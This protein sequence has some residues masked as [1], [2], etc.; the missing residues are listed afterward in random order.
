MGAVLDRFFGAQHEGRKHVPDMVTLGTIECEYA[1]LLHNSFCKRIGEG[2]LR[3]LHDLGFTAT[4][5]A[6]CICHNKRERHF[7]TSPRMLG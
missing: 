2:A 1:P 5:L 3:Q 7:L 4:R 6:V